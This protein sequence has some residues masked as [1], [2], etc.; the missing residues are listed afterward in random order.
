MVTEVK[1]WIPHYPPPHKFPGED[2]GFTTATTGEVKVYLCSSCAGMPIELWK[3]FPPGS[4]PEGTMCT[5]KT[6]EFAEIKMVQRTYPGWLDKI[7]RLIPP[8]GQYDYEVK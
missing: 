6:D 1:I 8:E 4:E 7:I 3:G 5:L 2:W